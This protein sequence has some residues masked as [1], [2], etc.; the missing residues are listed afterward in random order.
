MTPR[1][2]LRNEDCTYSDLY[3]L[4]NCRLNSFVNGFKAC[5]NIGGHFNGTISRFQ[6]YQHD[7]S[8]EERNIAEKLCVMANTKV[9]VVNTVEQ[10]HYIRTC[11]Y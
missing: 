8:N 4:I 2:N 11:L 6:K 5:F 10:N 9:T 7:I 1:C 3:L